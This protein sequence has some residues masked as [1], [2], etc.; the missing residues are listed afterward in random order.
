MQ[1]PENLSVYHC[2]SFFSWKREREWLN[3][4]GIA[5]ALTKRSVTGEDGVLL[6]ISVCRDPD[7]AVQNVQLQ[8]GNWPQRFSCCLLSRQALARLRAS[9]LIYISTY[10]AELSLA[11]AEPHPPKHTQALA[12]GNIGKIQR[13]HQH[14]STF[15][16]HYKARSGISQTFSLLLLCALTPDNLKAQDV[17]HLVV[18]KTELWV[19]YGLYGSFHGAV[20]G[21]GVTVWAELDSE[22]AEAAAY[23]SLAERNTWENSNIYW[24]NVWVRSKFRLSSRFRT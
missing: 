10:A 3:S 14:T 15:K 1:R 20:V 21:R 17:S 19:M 2:L 16:T 7:P 22:M 8:L 18:Y 5:R 9:T 6:V 13:P 23:M 11:L 12:L 24:K 4:P